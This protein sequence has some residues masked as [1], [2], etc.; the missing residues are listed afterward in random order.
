[1]CTFILIVVN[2]S[3]TYYVD[4][5]VVTSSVHSG[6][7]QVQRQESKEKLILIYQ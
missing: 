2:E 5:A 3:E 6:N 1:M 4:V 7:L